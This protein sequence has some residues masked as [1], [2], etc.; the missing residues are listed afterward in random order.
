MHDD[1]GTSEEPVSVQR[2]AEIV[3]HFFV[4][5]VKEGIVRSGEAAEKGTCVPTEVQVDLFLKISSFF[6]VVVALQMTEQ[7]KQ[8]QR[9]GLLGH[10]QHMNVN[11]QQPA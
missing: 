3:Q 8:K 10:P 9:I 1:A 11:P 5:G 6:C 4:S 2:R 7:R